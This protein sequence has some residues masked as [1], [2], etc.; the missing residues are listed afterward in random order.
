M[1]REEQMRV[2]I[3][4]Y[5]ENNMEILD[6]IPNLNDNDNIFELG[7]VSSLFA[8]RLLTFVEKKFCIKIKD[9][10]I[11]LKNFS[12]INNIVQMINQ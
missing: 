5:I 9:E 3:R 7:F 4:E 2:E 6:D 10:D 12:T 8:M 1:G 11:N